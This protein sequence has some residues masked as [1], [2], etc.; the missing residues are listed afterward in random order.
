M[1]IWGQSKNTANLVS[2]TGF[3]VEYFYSD[4]KYPGGRIHMWALLPVKR[5]EQAK[6][7]LAGV[8]TQAQRRQLSLCM[9]EDILDTLDKTTVISGTTVISCDADV[10]TVASR[11]GVDILETGRDGGYAVDVLKGVEAISD[12][13]IDKVIII[14]ADVPELD[15]TDLAYLDRDHAG[16]V[17]L[18]PAGNDGG[19]NGLVLTP[20]LSI[21]LMYGENSFDKF[22]KEAERRQVTVNIARP[23]GLA[24]DID[25]PEDLLAL[26]QQPGGNR[27]WR[28]ARSL[29]FA[30]HSDQTCRDELNGSR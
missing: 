19:T 26:R 9:L 28:F 2:I 17:T 22:R 4:P 24:R 16:G 18:C 11:Q 3:I 12:K 8:L 23:N 14:P 5:L 15:E 10:I 13:G 21:G 1:D 20:P 6:L 25:R 29:K 27:T 30:D 7:R